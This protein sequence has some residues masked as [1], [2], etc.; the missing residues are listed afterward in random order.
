MIRL[1][2][3]SKVYRKGSGGVQALERLD[4]DINSGEFL[5]IQGPSGCGKSTLLLILG[6]ML[7]PS[8]GRVEV[9][10]TNLYRLSDKQRARFRAE[11]IGFVFQMFHLIPYLTVAENIGLSTTPPGSRNKQAHDRMPEVLERLHLS[12]RSS[13]FPAELSAG[14]KQRTAVGRAILKKPAFI[15]ADEPTGNLDPDNSA[16]IFEYLSEFHKL[17]HT[18]VT[19]THGTGAGSFADRILN[20]DSGRILALTK[21]EED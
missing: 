20:L 17:G 19:V 21:N 3:I 2:D 4:L 11:H 9:D 12:E 1:T 7:H 16:E 5:V 18:V 13:H 14:E 15:L 8:T 10:G 6:G